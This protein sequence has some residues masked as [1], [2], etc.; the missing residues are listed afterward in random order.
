MQSIVIEDRRKRP[1]E[2]RVVA[3]AWCKGF[4]HWEWH[5]RRYVHDEKPVTEHEVLP[6]EVT[7]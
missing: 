4:A 2:E 7:R 3:C 1:R 5:L 6:Y